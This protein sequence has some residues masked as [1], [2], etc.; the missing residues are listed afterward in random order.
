[1]IEEKRQPHSKA[2]FRD[3]RDDCVKERVEDRKPEHIVIEK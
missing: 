3:G 2:E 1:V